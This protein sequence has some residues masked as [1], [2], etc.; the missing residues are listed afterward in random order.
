[1][2][3]PV[4]QMMIGSGVY[5]TSSYNST[6]TPP[7]LLG[8]TKAIFRPGSAMAVSLI[9]RTPLAFKPRQH[10]LEMVDLKTQ[11]VHP[12]AAFSQEFRHPRIIGWLA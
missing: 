3:I 9:R 4:I 1:M 2:I 10:L 11:V 12:A 7:V 5:F 6:S 8:W